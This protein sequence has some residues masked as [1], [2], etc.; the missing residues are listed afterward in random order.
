MPRKTIKSKTPRKRVSTAE[1]PSPMPQYSAVPPT[2]Q[3]KSQILLVLL[4]I[5]ISFFTGYLFFKVKNLEQ[6]SQLA[7]APN[8]PA[9][10]ARPTELKIKKP[11]LNKEHLRGSKNARYVW[12]EYSDLECPFCKKIHPDLV[13]LNK[14]YEGKV[15]WIFRHFPLS[16]HPKAQKSGEAVEC[17]ADQGG[18]D[19]F[20][21]LNDLIFERMP[22]MELSQLPQLASEIGLDQAEFQTCLDNG[23]FEKKV[24][25][26]LAE[27]TKAGVQATPTGVLYDMKTGKSQLVEGAQPYDSLKKAVDDFLAQNK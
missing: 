15:S 22:A 24:K 11:D 7:G 18:N 25:D 27:G 10:P 16:F 26:G 13:K 19:A 21:K 4:L 20:W 6:G 9:Q 12:V 1:S 17:A 14:E 2:P 23:T 5:V 3:P 8:Q